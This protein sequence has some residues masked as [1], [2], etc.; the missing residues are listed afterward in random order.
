MIYIFTKKETALKGIFKKETMFGAVAALSK[1][2]PGSGDISYL[3]ISGLTAAD[4]KKA[5]TQ[6]KKRCKN[7]PWGIIDPK[8]MVKDP[9]GC[10]FEGASDYLG[11]AA[12]KSVTPQR[13]QSAVSWRSALSRTLPPETAGT[14]AK[15]AGLD[16][17]GSGMDAAG[18]PKT[19]IKLPVGKFPGWKNI[20][21][22]KTMPFYLLY[23]SLQGKT[24]LNSRF[25]E[26]AYTQLHQRLLAHLYQHFQEAEGLIWMDSGKDCLFLLP[27]KAKSAETAVKACIRLLVSAPLAALETLNLTIPVNFIFALHYGQAAYKPPGKTGTVVSDAVNFIFHLGAKKAELGR[28]TISG[29]LPDDTVPKELEDCFVSAGEY[30]GRKIWH[31]KKFSYVRNWI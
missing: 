30:E 20:P 22:G 26:A 31:T 6:L 29:E 23:C 7:G 27:A 25:G 12:L 17:A 15:T 4:A 13:L 8:G 16:A 24:A 28:L 14:A 3:D 5:L 11:P 21:V 18:L 2:S 19:G 10:F 1:H 9:A